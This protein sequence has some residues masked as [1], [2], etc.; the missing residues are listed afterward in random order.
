MNR[1]ERRAVAHKERKLARKAGFPSPE[2]GPKQPAHSVRSNEIPNPS[3][4]NPKPPLRTPISQTL[5]DANRPA[6][7]QNHPKH[8]LARHNGAFRLLATED[9]A[10]FEALKHSLAEEHQP[11]TPTE[12]I[13]INEMAE[14][15]WLANRASNLQATCFDPQTGQVS[16][17]NLFSLYLRCQTTRQRSFQRALNQLLKLRSERR[18]GEA[19]FEAQKQKQVRAQ[20]DNFHAEVQ[21][22]MKADEDFIDNPEL[23][24]LAIRMGV[25]MTHNS[26]DLEALRSEFK[27]KC[28]SLWKETHAAAA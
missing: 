13:L 25:A 6:S 9:P 10:G 16:D 5:P 1:K 3:S 23:R 17:T 27:E 8:G 22:Q 28:R 2:P 15:T 11:S 26:P 19:G 21:K 7:S 18:K 14:S 24:S 12:A 4:M 20:M